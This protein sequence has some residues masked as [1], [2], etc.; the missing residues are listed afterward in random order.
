MPG[1]LGSFKSID[2]ED[3]PVSA[4]E[5][6]SPAT[7]IEHIAAWV[8]E[9]PGDWPQSATVPAIHGITDTIACMISGATDD[10]AKGVRRTM[11]AWSNGAGTSTFVSD[12]AKGVAPLVAHANGTAAH[13]QD[14]DDNFLA[15]MTHASAVLVPALF[16]IGEEA[17]ASGADLIDAYIVGLE[18]HAAVGRGVNRSHYLAGWH[19]TASVGCIGTAAACARL[20]GLD[21]EQTAMA[22]SLAVSMA[23]G[24][25]GQFGS[26]AKP[27]QAGMAAENAVKAASFAR[28]GVIGRTT[29]LE[30]RFGFMDLAGGGNAPGWDFAKHPLGNPL[31]I[32]AV[33][34]APKCHPCCGSTHKSIDNL[35]DLKRDH[36]FAPEDVAAIHAEVNESNVRNLS[37]DNPQNEME[38][39]FSMQY[40]LA[41]AL[42]HDFLSL[43]DFTPEAV[44]RPERRALMPLTT[45]SATPPEAETMAG[46]ADTSLPH[47]LTV[48]L[49]S[50][51]VLTAT[52][53]SAKGTL[54]D[55]F[56]DDDRWRKFE[57]CC[58]P[59][60]GEAR[61]AALYETC[62]G[63]AD[64][65]ALTD[66]AAMMAAASAAGVK[67][68]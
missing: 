68:A 63:L 18:C 5:T 31:V 6:D 11:S 44:M 65:T 22:M 59:V 43:S 24:V 34:L 30:G 23:A 29:V 55:P 42:A 41:V 61:T 21:A 26:H 13:A 4:P 7:V 39:R 33:G 9:T 12:G 14:F 2:P 53:R 25:K 50:G 54:G 15:A 46:G 47:T 51:D 16:A 17:N 38:G 67:V 45:M 28:D 57:D 62:G 20:L 60:L 27:F 49:K 58:G 52:R 56:T 66:L 36:G 10:A 64:V 1:R 32:E 40:C 35:M 19:A 8:A 3:H 37:F 48:T